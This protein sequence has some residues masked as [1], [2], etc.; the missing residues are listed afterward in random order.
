[1]TRHLG[2]DA[3]T[4]RHF[5][6]TSCR[7]VR[8]LLVKTKERLSVKRK[9]GARSKV[10]TGS[11][12]ATWSTV[13]DNRT[14]QPHLI[15]H[16]NISTESYLFIQFSHKSFLLLLAFTFV[17]FS[18]IFWIEFTRKDSSGVKTYPLIL[19]PYPCHS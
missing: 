18:A 5:L 2:N 8:W 19:C 15:A 12:D 17:I 13:M 3:R 4:M 9:V 16:R 7:G 10:K 1:M 11:G 6:Q 14:S